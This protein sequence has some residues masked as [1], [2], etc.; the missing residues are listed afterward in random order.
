MNL[1][2]RNQLLEEAEEKYR[3]FSSSLIPNVDNILG[4]RI[5]T[6]RKIA[7]QLAKG[8]WKAYLATASDEYFE[9]IMLQG[10]VIGYA[11]ADIEE[12]LE[13]IARFI[14]KINNWSVCDSFC[15]GL[16]ITQKHKERVW[17]FIQPYLA[18]D[19]PYDI[20]FGVVMLLNYYADDEYMDRVLPLL[21]RIKQDHYYVKMAVAWAIATCFTNVP[22]RTM[23]YL[24]GD[25]CTLDN[26]TYNKSLQKITES[27]RI[28]A[29]T[30]QLIRSMKRK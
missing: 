17:S 21:D 26:W 16:K 3:S 19:Q 6:L 25:E 8:D 14:P 24:R 28:D 2:I 10:L 20:R 5:P 4:V 18:S 22:D 15:I 11:K 12:K 30:K 7:G 27:L 1:S 29:E 23:A 13:A 9:E